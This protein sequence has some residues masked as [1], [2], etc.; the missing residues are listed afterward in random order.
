MDRLQG[1]FPSPAFLKQM[2]ANVA[3]PMMYGYS[4]ELAGSVNNQPL[5]ATVIS[6]KISGVSLSVEASGKDDTNTLSFDGDVLINGTTCLTT[7]PAIAHVSGEASQQ[8]TTMKT[9]DTGITQA[10]LNQAA[11]SI[12]QGDVISCTLTL[13]RTASPT[14]EMETPCVVVE[15]EPSP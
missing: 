14:T 2:A 10:V 9:G 12:S 3:A 15:F 8:K 11:N 6:G 5:G 7:K 13:T 4:G 1:P